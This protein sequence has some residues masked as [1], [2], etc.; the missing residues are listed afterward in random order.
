MGAKTK[1]GIAEQFAVDL[2]DHLEAL[3][4]YEKN[5]RAIAEGK[6]LDVDAPNTPGKVSRAIP[7][8][9]PD[10]MRPEHRPSNSRA[11]GG[12]SGKQPKK[13]PKPRT[14]RCA[15]KVPQ[16]NDVGVCQDCGMPL[17]AAK[18]RRG[19]P[20]DDP[21][22]P[23]IAFQLTPV[24]DALLKK[25]RGVSAGDFVRFWL[26][27]RKLPM[28]AKTASDES[29][30]AHQFRRGGDRV[31]GAR[32]VGA[33]R[34][35]G[36]IAAVERFER[37]PRSLTDKLAAQGVR[38]PQDVGDVA[39]TGFEIFYA[40]RFALLHHSNPLRIRS[41]EPSA[42]A[43]DATSAEELEIVLNRMLAFSASTLKLDVDNASYNVGGGRGDP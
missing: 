24:F 26:E 9:M 3:E 39:L 37:L 22:G 18:G 2:R 14:R 43:E 6:I 12:P 32:D 33:R 11:S 27:A 17:P 15:C 19:R 30:Q 23:P 4:R 36:Q 34:K 38:Q 41:F 10:S 40:A 13:P 31:R 8:A 28:W 35:W 20:S 29:E 5:R 21:K 16:T 7:E 25:S 42:F 1:S